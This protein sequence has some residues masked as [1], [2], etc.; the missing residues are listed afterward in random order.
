MDVTR[1][2]QEVSFGL[3]GLQTKAR[4]QSESNK[5][6]AR[7]RALAQVPRHPTPSFREQDEMAMTFF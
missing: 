5:V 7:R 3:T 4:R 2:A 6:V 1:R